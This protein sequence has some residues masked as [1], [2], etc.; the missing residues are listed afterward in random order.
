[1]SG[2]KASRRRKSGAAFEQA[3]ALAQAGKH[4]EADA[5]FAKL[6]GDGTAGYRVLARLREAAELAPT[7][8]NG[9]RQGL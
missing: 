3:V 1:M 6:A 4:Q 9:R 2:G 7:D 8:R 5:A